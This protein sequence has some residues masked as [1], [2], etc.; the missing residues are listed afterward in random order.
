M[1]P[2]KSRNWFTGFAKATS[3]ITGRPIAFMMPESLS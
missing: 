2:T 3:R 1:R